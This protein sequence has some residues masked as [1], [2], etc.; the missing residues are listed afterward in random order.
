[1]GAIVVIAPRYSFGSYCTKGI[2]K[3]GTANQAASTIGLV[4][5]IPNSKATMYPLIIPSKIGINPRKPL[6]HMLKKIVL[7]HI[8]A[9]M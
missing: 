5:T 8:K 7:A 6:S 2:S 3:L 1:M 4:S 9:S